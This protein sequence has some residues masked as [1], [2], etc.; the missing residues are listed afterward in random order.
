MLALNGLLGFFAITMFTTSARY[1]F[2]NMTNID[3]LK[4]KNFVHNLAIRVP[5]GTQSCEKYKVI[6]YPISKPGDLTPPSSA[7]T[8]ARGVATERDMLATRTFAIVK[9]ELGEN[10]WDLGYWRNWKSIMGNGLIDWLLPIKD[11]PCATY[12]N[13]ESFY[14]M[15]AVLQRV[16]ER[17][18]LPS[19]TDDE[20][21]F[22]TSKNEVSSETQ[23]KERQQNKKQEQQGQQ[24]QAHG[25]A[26]ANL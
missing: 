10:P 16:R 2:L 4:S 14:E 21:G 24:D 1:A 19:L 12:E 18:G 8:G 25:P 3:Q 15:G 17:F 9:T 5:R 11:S 7:E 6:T 26:A 23:P 22:T 20:K 13:N